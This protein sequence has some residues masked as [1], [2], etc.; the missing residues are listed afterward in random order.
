MLELGCGFGR[1]LAALNESV[2]D[3][4]GLDDHPGLLA[5]ARNT[6]GATLVLGDMRSFS[7]GR[8]FDRVLIPYNG[9]YCLLTDD[10]VR[11][12]LACCRRH[13]SASGQLV[14]DVYPYESAPSDDDIEQSESDE[15]IVQIEMGGRSYVVYE[16]AEFDRSTGIATVTYRYVQPDG[17]TDTG[18]IRQRALAEDHL[19]GLVAQEG[20]TI[21][22]WEGGF[23]GEAADEDA[24]QWVVTASAGS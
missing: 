8:T 6:G 22:R 19:R 2:D 20:L 13:L 11:A 24:E 1:I 21:A 9:L 7:L 4:W 14:L 3:L 5:E 10:D 23:V 17:A 15:P 18:V 12:C 16:S